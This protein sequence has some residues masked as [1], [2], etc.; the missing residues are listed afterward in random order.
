MIE[1]LPY[2]LCIIWIV[3]AV[4]CSASAAERNTTSKKQM[5][6]PEPLSDISGNLLDLENSGH[7]EIIQ[8]IYGTTGDFNKSALIWTVKVVKPLL[9]EDAMT[10]LR[11]WSDVRFYRT[12]DG[13]PAELHATELYYSARIVTGVA[14]REPLA[15]NDRFHIWI[16]ANATLV[17]TLKEGAADSAVF[18]R[19]RRLPK[20]LNDI[21]GNFGDLEK[22]GYF[23]IIKEEFGRTKEL[24]EEALIWTLRVVKPLSY[25][26]AMI[27]LRRL[28]DVRFYRVVKDWRKQLHSTELYYPSYIRTGA[29]HYENL[30]Q[31]D[32]L[33]VWVPL[34]EEQV[35]H[36]KH[37][38]ANTVEFRELK[39]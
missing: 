23:R 33:Q 28:G 17:E 7:F 22:S 11:A 32:W 31:D 10:L 1:R 9:C 25:Q 6:F 16:L 36:L 15:L 2:C 24:R 37:H 19:Y 35:L 13:G 34:D 39:R 18:S 8:G 12:G 29:I 38:R 14:G 26:H 5:R 4:T 3:V 30:A 21:T 27:R 20:P